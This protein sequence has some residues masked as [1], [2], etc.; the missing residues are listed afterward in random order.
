MVH[1]VVDSPITATM[2]GG[3]AK[4]GSTFYESGVNAGA[5]P[6]GLPAAG[7]VFGSAN[8]ANHTFTFQSYSGPNAVMMDT[9][10]TSGNL[11][12]TNPGAYSAL[13][14]L[15]SDGNGSTTFT[16]TPSPALR[17]PSIRTSSSTRRT[18]STW[19]R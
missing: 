14:F 11:T 10:N 9:S 4:S 6:T 12:L 5:P 8:D 1:I 17:S 7:V 3:T 19:T 18:S 2:D 15:V 16:A 13:S